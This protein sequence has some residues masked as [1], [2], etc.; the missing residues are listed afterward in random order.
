LNRHAHEYTRA[1]SFAIEELARLSTR[2]RPK[3][4]I[5]TMAVREE[6]GDGR[7]KISFWPLLQTSLQFDLLGRS[8]EPIRVPITADRSDPVVSQ[9]N[10]LAADSMT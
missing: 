5:T 3:D 7:N 10:L 2:T 6:T 1:V 9:G 4:L 8:L